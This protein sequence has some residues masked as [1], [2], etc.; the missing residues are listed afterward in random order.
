ME[1][2]RG[3]QFLGKNLVSVEEV[4]LG[5]EHM[6]DLWTR[7]TRTRSPL[8]EHLNHG[9][10]GGHGNPWGVFLL[11][12]VFSRDVTVGQVTDKPRHHPSIHPGL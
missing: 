5:L 10:D 9:V 12:G 4:R 7:S 6:R 8:E 11:S 1:G 2:W 3:S